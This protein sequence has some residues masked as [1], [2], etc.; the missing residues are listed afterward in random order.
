MLAVFVL[1]GGFGWLAHRARVQREAVAVIRAAGGSVLYS[2]QWNGLLPS[3]LA[4]PRAPDWLV[5]LIGVDHFGDVV[6]VHL[7]NP[8]SDVEIAHVA[9][10]SRLETLLIEPSS[11]DDNRLGSLTT[12]TRLKALNLGG[13]GVTDAGLVHLRPF[14][15]LEDLSLVA[16]SITDE[17]LSHVAEA[18]SLQRLN[19]TNTRVTDVGL[20]YLHWLPN[21]KRLNIRSTQIIRAASVASLRD[22]KPNLMI[23]H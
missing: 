8:A 23:S 7:P 4:K 14:S 13:S 18:P 15:S 17:G 22:A 20:A 19:L 21:L 5:T 2:W 3:P 11:I 6:Y 10:L 1:G 12:L 9:Q 16:T